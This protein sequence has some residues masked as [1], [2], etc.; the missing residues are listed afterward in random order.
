[1]RIKVIDYRI[2]TQ[3]TVQAI[4]T[5]FRDGIRS[6][7]KGLIGFVASKALDWE[8]FSPDE[9]DDPFAI[10]DD[11][12][13][14][15]AVGATYGIRHARGPRIT[16]FRR[17]LEANSGGAVQLSI[18][19]R[20]GSREAVLRHAGDLSPASKSSVREVLDR[21]SGTDSGLTVTET[22]GHL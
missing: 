19:D 12:K 17:M 8:F 10:F 5:M 16:E 13:P 2:K 21:L 1:M 6:R 9:R 11:D 15:F 4:A 14:D 18:W 22:K 7:P 3:L 20:G